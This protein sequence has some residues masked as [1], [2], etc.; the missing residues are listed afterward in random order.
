MA[1]F[2]IQD[3]EEAKRELLKYKLPI[4]DYAKQRAEEE[5]ELA[6]LRKDPDWCEMCG[7]YHKEPLLCQVTLIR[8]E[9]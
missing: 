1:D 4:P 3:P 5:A 8:E 6:E 7:G 9:G 2:K